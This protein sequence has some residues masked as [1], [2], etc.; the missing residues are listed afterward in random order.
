MK[1]TIIDRDKGLKSILA[2]TKAFKNSCVKV[3]ITEDVGG[4]TNGGDATVAQY[5]AWNEM[6]TDRIPS[7][8]FIRDWVDGNRERITQTMQS[9][10]RYVQDGIMPADVALGRLGQ[11]GQSGIQSYIITGDFEENATS[12]K[13]R[14]GSSKPLIDTGTLRNNIRYQIVKTPPSKVQE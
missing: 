3:G 12:T 1:S 14:K 10:F 2:Q 11:F 13:K 7:R 6:G 4:K 8:P 5:A 9:L